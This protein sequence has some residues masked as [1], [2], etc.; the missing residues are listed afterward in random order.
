MA[1]PSGPTPP[2]GTDPAPGLEPASEFA[3]P[4]AVGDRGTEIGPAELTDALAPPSAEVREEF[5]RLDEEGAAAEAQSALSDHEWLTT[6]QPVESTATSA[7]E[8][9]SAPPGGIDPPIG[10]EE[11][12]GSAAGDSSAESVSAPTASRALG[13]RFVLTQKLASLTGDLWIDDAEG[14]QVFLVDGTSFVLRRTLVLR[15]R[16]GA[17]LYQINQALAHLHPTFEISRGEDVVATI[18]EAL[19]TVTDY[20]F[21]IDL[22]IGGQLVAAGNFLG[23]EFRIERAGTEVIVASRRFASLRDTYDV[24]IAPGFD[25]PLGLAIMVAIEQMQRHDF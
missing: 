7:D 24:T 23:R 16:S 9:P 6:P 20:H 15:D 21:T 3:G 19:F 8:Q 13:G 25:V 10:G 2:G 22:S 1:K 12:R 17:E 11:D 4:N 14:N 5:R 18:Q